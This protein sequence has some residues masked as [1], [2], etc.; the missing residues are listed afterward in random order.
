MFCTRQEGLESL[1]RAQRT[2][3]IS[4]IRI[5]KGKSNSSKTKHKSYEIEMNSKPRRA[6]GGLGLLSHTISVQSLQ[7]SIPKI[8][9]LERKEGENREGERRAPGGRRQLAVHAKEREKERGEGVFNP[10]N[11]Q[12]Q[13][14]KQPLDSIKH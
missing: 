4:C 1:R 11:S 3:T 12:P 13:K 2:I 14:T 10:N 8:L 7:E 9:S 5:D 6:Q